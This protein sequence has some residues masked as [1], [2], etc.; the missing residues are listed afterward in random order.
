MRRLITFLILG[1]ATPM[2]AQDGP[3]TNG[4]NIPVMTDANGYVIVAAQTYSA[5]D[6]PRRP[7]GNALV[8]TDANGYLIV[9][10]PTGLGA[11]IG[12][13]VNSGTTGSVLF[14]GSGPVLAQDN[15]NLFWNDSTDT[16]RTRTGGIT[17]D[18]ASGNSVSSSILTFTGYNSIS[19]A[20]TT[21]L[22]QAWDAVNAQT[23][24]TI[25]SSAAAGYLH[26][27]ENGSWVL[28]SANNIISLIGNVT[29]PN[30]DLLFYPVNGAVSV[31][32]RGTS[33]Q[34]VPVF[35]TK[36]TSGTQNANLQEWQTSAGSPV[37]GLDKNG[38]VGV[39]TA[40]FPSTG[41]AV[42]AIADGTAPATLASNTA[43]F[44]A[45]DVGGTT[46]LF[47]MDESGTTGQVPMMTG[48]PVQGDIPFGA[49]GTLSRLAKDANATRYISNTGASNDPAWAQINLANGVTG[50]L[51]VG[52]GGTGATTF[53][54]NG[55][56]YGNT[57]SA[58][59]V[60]AQGATNSVLT[61]SA[62]AP[63]F[64]TTPTVTGLTATGASSNIPLA[65]PPRIIISTVFEDAARF[66]TAV[67]G[68]GVV[69][70]GATTTLD[71][72]ATGTSAARLTWIADQAGKIF[73]SVPVESGAQIQ[74]SPVGTDLQA[75]FGFGS[76]T[77]DGSGITFTSSHVGFKFIRAASGATS[78]YATQAD[79]TTETASSALAT[80]VDGDIFDLSFQIVS[81]SEVKYWWKKNGGS[82]SS[83]TTL[84]T[85]VPS[86]GNGNVR[87]AISNAG[88]ATQSTLITLGTFF[89][90]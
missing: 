7:F 8:R 16:L 68:G 44:Y 43:V 50:T 2:L 81:S 3:L 39:G 30:A 77:V 41:T 22:Q 47:G 21:T 12:S 70:I 71:T 84:T 37:A 74:I 66:V 14:V 23:R 31:I 83:A 11:A 72:S 1:L 38:S 42:A 53:T 89:T 29:N 60:T 85:N 35:V 61:A 40:S 86:T 65:T 25:Q 79:G 26:L 49:T 80:M 5:P 75:F 24:F 6:G 82:W 13:S 18:V 59:Q 28:S 51:P 15:A 76:I 78:L 20:K 9:T 90:R 46:K 10:N 56:L 57:T 67:N 64:S 19:A 88:V 36:A 63:S 58:V 34:N 33:T 54:A 4:A 62:G 48:T 73:T 69:S 32:A 52:N 27:F 45:D 55:V 17:L 87:F